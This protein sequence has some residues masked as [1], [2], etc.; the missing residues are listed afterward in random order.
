[1]SR[2][3]AHS[4]EGSISHSSGH[5]EMSI[6]SLWSLLAIIFGSLGEEPSTLNRFFESST[7]E[8]S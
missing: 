7:D 3:P 8:G 5:G 1:M 6:R 2:I 4:S